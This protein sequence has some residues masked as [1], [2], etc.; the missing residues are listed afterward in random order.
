MVSAC[1]VTYPRGSLRE[2]LRH[3]QSL[4]CSHLSCAS[5]KE[6]E[7]SFEHLEHVLRQ[8]FKLQDFLP[9]SR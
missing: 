2:R 6:V 8:F 4:T 3:P 9:L 1:V 5:R 7:V